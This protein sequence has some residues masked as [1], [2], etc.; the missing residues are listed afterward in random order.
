MSVLRFR[1]VQRLYNNGARKFVIENVPL[2]GC[3]PYL[4]AINFGTHGQC[5]E[6]ANRA[7]GEFNGVLQNLVDELNAGLPGATFLYADGFNAQLHV[8]NNYQKYGKKT[9]HLHGGR[10]KHG[11]CEQLAVSKTFWFNRLELLR[12][13]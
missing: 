1:A 13:S 2:L 11:K 5:N 3:I 10:K 9:V 12:S 7:C 6:R 8:L 4:R